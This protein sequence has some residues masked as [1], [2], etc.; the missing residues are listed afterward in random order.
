LKITYEKNLMIVDHENGQIDKYDKAHLE[1]VKTE[2]IRKFN[3]ANDYVIRIN[4]HL[5]NIELQE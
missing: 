4:T 2:A 5:L 1:M 3:L